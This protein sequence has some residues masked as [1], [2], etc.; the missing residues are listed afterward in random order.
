MLDKDNAIT[1]KEFTSLITVLQS[2]PNW[3][4]RNKKYLIIILT[5]WESGVRLGELLSLRK[6]DVVD[7]GGKTYL[8]VKSEKRRMTGVYRMVPIP[9][10]LYLALSNYAHNMKPN[11][12]IFPL[13]PSSIRR[14]LYRLAD[15]A[16]IRRIHPH[17]FRHAWATRM[18]HAGISQPVLMEMGGW[19]RPEMVEVYF[20][21]SAE[22]IYSLVDKL[23]WQN[24]KNIT[25]GQTSLF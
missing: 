10:Y 24:E 19:T 23:V 13:N 22:D 3:R 5:L 16:G 8:H 6:K 14:K 4:Y 25:I 2:E 1:E 7:R 11:E 12:E 20:T 9:R 18:V 15:N 17:M 21:P